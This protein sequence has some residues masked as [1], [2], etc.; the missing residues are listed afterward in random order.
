MY[1]A[2]SKGSKT[3]IFD[4][5]DECKK[6]VMGYKGAKFKKFS[7]KADAENFVKGIKPVIKQVT[8]DPDILYV[9][10]DGSCLGNGTE[11]S[12]AGLGIYFH[13]DK[14]DNVSLRHRGNQTN[15]SAELRAIYEAL[16]ILKDQIK[17]GKKIE[18]YTDSKYAIRCINE[19]GKNN[20]DINWKEDIPNKS[21]VKSCYLL[22]TESKSINPNLKVLHVKGH[23][24]D[25]DFHSLN[26]EKADLLAR[27]GAA[28]PL[29][30]DEK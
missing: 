5:W 16:T 29:P 25:Q 24:G 4:T 19:F 18:I 30:N 28:L 9:Y 10:T 20:V 17:E 15:N 11:S 22:F 8:I 26:N 13:S 27:S 23:S 21:L 7:K 1:Y 6:Y 12:S 3:G 2:I 14:F